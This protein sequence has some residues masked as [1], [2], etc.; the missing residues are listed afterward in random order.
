M[1]PYS[2]FAEL[3][4]IFDSR[5]LLLSKYAMQYNEVLPC[6]HWPIWSD[7]LYLF[8]L[9]EA[10][11]HHLSILSLSVLW[12]II[13]T[14][15]WLKMCEYPTKQLNAVL[16]DKDMVHYSSRMT[17]R[18]LRHHYYRIDN[19]SFILS[20]EVSTSWREKYRE[21]IANTLVDLYRNLGL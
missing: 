1:T 11:K 10:M 20:S 7:Q 17:S 9:K 2:P 6:K 5:F 13:N 12:K 8:T 14:V 21:Y 4:I 16:W 15:L 18:L 19:F 3:N